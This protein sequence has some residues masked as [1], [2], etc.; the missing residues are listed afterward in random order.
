MNFDGSKFI[1]QLAKRLVA[2]FEFSAEAGTPGLV[3]AAKEHPARAQ[4]AEMLPKGVAVGSGIVIDSYG[5]FSKQ[6]DIVVYENLCPVFTFNDTAEATFFPVEGVIATGE[7]KSTLSK[8]ELK[9]AFEKCC[10]VKKLRR[11]AV[12]IDDALSL[13]AT[14]EFRNYGELNCISG[15]KEQE[16]DQ[17]KNSIDQIFTFILCEKFGASPKTM[18]KNSA[19]FYRSDK[20]AFGPNFIVSLK[21]GFITPLNTAKRSITRSPMEADEIMFCDESDSAFAQLLSPLR[22]YVR[23]GRTVNTRHYERYY[24]PNGEKPELRV[25]CTEPL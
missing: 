9:D 8:N 5:A 11:H 12:A 23:S 16:Y 10:S 7:V 3:G 14:V 24:W 25:V 13:D 1:S 6:Q 20:I 22:I 2:E 15:T 17:D 18:L 19:E 21:D 4:L